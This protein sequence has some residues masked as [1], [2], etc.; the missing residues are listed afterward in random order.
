MDKQLDQ[1]MGQWK[2][3]IQ[4]DGWMMNRRM[5]GGREG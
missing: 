1:Y 5:E 3:D 2:E 4:R